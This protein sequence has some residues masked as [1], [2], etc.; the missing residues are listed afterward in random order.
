MYPHE[1]SLVEKYPADEFAIVGV[2]SES[3]VEAAQEAIKKNNLTWMNFY[4]GGTNGPISTRW[5]VSGWPTIY[6]IDAQGIIRYKDVRGEDMD[7]AIEELVAEL[8][9]EKQKAE[10]K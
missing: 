6:L 8:R 2:N 10:T 4:D 5:N 7:K 3:T 9:T 1:R